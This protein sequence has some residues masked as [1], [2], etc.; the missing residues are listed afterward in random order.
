MKKNKEGFTLVEVI[1]VL[2]I[3]AILAAILVPSYV[4]YIEKANEK[5]CQVNRKTILRY[6]DLYDNYYGDDTDFETYVAENYGDI[7]KMCPSGGTYTLVVESGVVTLKCSEHDDVTKQI[8]KEVNSPQDALDNAEI[9]YNVFDDIIQQLIDEYGAMRIQRKFVTLQGDDNFYFGTTKI[10]LS[11]KILEAID[12]TA[13]DNKLSN[14]KIYFDK[15]DEGKYIPSASYVV[16]KKGSYW[17]KYSE[18]AQE[19]GT[20]SE[21]ASTPPR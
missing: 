11:E 1:V 5:I 14:G 20:G 21:H 3:L 19:M 6:Y 18:S 13:V 10:N 9:V 15:N 4:K 7:D 17:G 2:V 8:F 12:L 16:I